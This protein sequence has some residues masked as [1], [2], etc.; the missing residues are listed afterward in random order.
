VLKVLH[1]L[2]S[3]P[4]TV[5]GGLEIHAL[6]LARALNERG[7]EILMV[8][9]GK[10][11]K[12]GGEIHRAPAGFARM[13][14]AYRGGQPLHPP[15]PD[16][17][18]AREL[19]D[20]VD[21]YNPHVVHSHGNAF[22]SVGLALTGRS[23]RWVHTL[24]DY[25][26]LCPKATLWRTPERT[27]CTTSMTAGCVPCYLAESRL[28]PKASI[29][30]AS[31]RGI[32]LVAG[33]GIARLRRGRQ[34][35]RFIAVSNYVREVHERHLP[36]TRGRIQV[37]YNWAMEERDQVSLLPSLPERF[38]LFV[39]SASIHKGLPFLLEI[40]R[41]LPQG[42]PLVAFVTGPLSLVQ[43]MRRLG[44]PQVHIF[45]NV[46]HGAVV[47]AWQQ[48]FMGVIPSM[49]PETSSLVALEAMRAGCPVVASAVGALPE[50]IGEAGLFAPPGDKL[51]WQR[52]L[53]ALVSDD[54]LRARLALLGR[55]R[56]M[57]LFAPEGAIEAL[58]SL[59]HAVLEEHVR[60]QLR[61]G[62]RCL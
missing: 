58:I 57:R 12:R 9:P 50:I 40:W 5:T 60:V 46:P 55:H 7:L 39:G 19:A 36:E 8:V 3:D 42:M 37:I 44:G 17:R 30:K 28:S 56:A 2:P 62:D 52:Q 35:D 34:P 26:L 20:L 23:V 15:W 48:A 21:Q 61:R 49:W 11:A 27:V 10:A 59:Y 51:A 1:V 41:R 18:F 29:T 45:H 24:H 13:S 33:T 4:G 38:A 53:Q 25:G 22:H 31:I 14:Y 43:Q 32:A 6:G 16:L 47:A 54:E